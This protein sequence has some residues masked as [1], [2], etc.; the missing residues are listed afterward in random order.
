[1]R[2]MPAETRPLLLNATLAGG[3]SATATRRLFRALKQSGVQAKLIVGD[4]SDGEEGVFSLTSALDRIVIK[5]CKGFE[6]TLHRMYKLKRGESFTSG[7][8]GARLARQIPRLGSNVLHFNQLNNGFVA[9][10]FLQDTRYPKI[11]T[12]HDWWGMTG[13]CHV[14]GSC[15]RHTNKCGGCPILGSKSSLDLSRANHHLKSRAL[16]KAGIRYVSVSRALQT[17]MQASA[18][19][20]GAAVDVIPNGLDLN[21]FRPVEKKLARDLLG[22]PPDRIVLTFGAN[23]AVENKGFRDVI[24]IGRHLANRVDRKK[25]IIARF[26]DNA[27]IREG[28]LGVECRSFGYVRDDLTLALLYSASDIVVVPSRLESFGLVAAEAIACGTPVLGYRTGGVVDIIDH[29]KNGF[30]GTLNSLETIIEGAHWLLDRIASPG[31]EQQLRNSAVAKARAAFDIM[32]VAQKYVELYES[33]LRH[34]GTS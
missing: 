20:R 16:R 30:L 19:T 27:P 3:G 17:D 7:W 13:G 33:T 12:L 18:S 29:Q 1:M 22:L 4:K 15:T 6:L 5:A 14:P 8:F 2:L 25:F 32:D 34:H 26:G 31:G 23:I 11:W 28:E 24:A 21:L 9:L 10:R